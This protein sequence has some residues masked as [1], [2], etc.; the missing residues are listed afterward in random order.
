M[1]LPGAGR[2]PQGSVRRDGNATATGDNDNAAPVLTIES[3]SHRGNTDRIGGTLI[4]GFAGID[5]GDSGTV[6]V[7][8]Y[9]CDNCTNITPVF[10]GTR[11]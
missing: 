9:A 11:R 7:Q 1:H 10:S 2:E 5:A 3:P 6:P 4:T 8:V